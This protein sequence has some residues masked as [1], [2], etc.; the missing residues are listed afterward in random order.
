MRR[1]YCAKPAPGRFW[2]RRQRRRPLREAVDYLVIGAGSAGCAL[3]GRLSEDAR[4]A[5]A[6]LEA[7]GR[8]DSIGDD[9]TD[10]IIRI[11]ANFGDLF[12]TERDWNYHT[13]PQAGLAGRRDYLPRGKLLGGSSSM[14]AM[15]YQRGHPSDYD[16]W[17]AAGNAG[18]SY[19]DVLP[20][21]LRM[22]H[23]ER[24][25]SPHHATGGPLNVVDLRDPNPLSQAFVAAAVECGFARNRDFNDGQQEGFGIYQV[26]QKNGERWSAAAAY[27]RPARGRAN[28]SV[29]S[30]AQVTRLLFEGRR[31]VGARYQ[32][33]GETREIRARR[34]V[35]LC[36]G[37]FNSPQ[38]L[39]LS[40]VGPAAQLAERGIPLVLDA[41]GVGQNLM[42]HILAPVA[43]HC[44]QP[45]TLLNKDLPEERERYEKE[46][47]GLLTSNLGEA[48]GF[49]RINPAAPA[50]EVQFHF[51]PDFFVLH[52]FHPLEGH[53]YT[54]Q[55]GLVVTKSRGE[56]RLQSADPLTPPAIDPRL[57]DDERDMEGMLWALKL[58]RR[59][60]AAEA[61]APYRGA[62]A[63]PGPEAQSD[64]ELRDYLRRFTNTIYHPAG[65]CKM[66]PAAERMAV[67]DARLR[68]HGIDGLRVADASIMPTII[69]ANTNAPCIMIGERAADFIKEDGHFSDGH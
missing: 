42:D 24:G 60:A 32:M 66:G 17:A 40:G 12:E 2:R 1:L 22:Q 62:E 51:G 34:E 57:Y 47:R 67:V 43:H 28:L 53:G 55:P 29:Q 48:G 25:A 61:F 39:L 44:L 16:G 4:C 8:D 5:V 20:Y 59:I 30:G 21:F 14:N 50:P 9:S 11:P 26:T 33:G 37:A 7:G 19:A 65:T 56:V 6:L 13:V 27:L 46:R 41:P 38:L 68:V 35:A 58:G 52:G 49:A 10:D 18:W 3:A 64:D 36:G 23:Q 31:C 45:I 69:N 54:I 15:V 63:L